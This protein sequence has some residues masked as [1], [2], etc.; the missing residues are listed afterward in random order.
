MFSFCMYAKDNN[1]Y[2]ITFHKK[3]F[4]FVLKNKVCQINYNND[5]LF[6]CDNTKMPAVP[7]KSINLLIPYGK[8]YSNYD[9]TYESESMGTSIKLYNNEEP[10][11]IDVP[12]MEKIIHK[13][14]SNCSV[15]MNKKQLKFNIDN[16]FTA[17]STWIITLADALNGKVVKQK[18]GK[19]G[20]ELTRWRN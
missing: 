16:S 11:T 13:T 4:A 5:S 20:E 18:S 1:E 2:E 15:I 8:E 17:S 10:T 19:E 7:C 3:D 9:I 6:Y 14:N 12:N